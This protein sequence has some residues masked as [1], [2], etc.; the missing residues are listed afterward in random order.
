MPPPVIITINSE[1]LNILIPLVKTPPTEHI[2]DIIETALSGLNHLAHSDSAIKQQIAADP[3]IFISIAKLAVVA[4]NDTNLKLQTLVALGLFANPERLAVR[5]VPNF[6]AMLKESMSPDNTSDVQSQAINTAGVLSFD[7]DNQVAM[8]Q[9]PGFLKILIDQLNNLNTQLEQANPLPLDKIAVIKNF[10][11]IIIA[12][13]IRL[14]SNSQNLAHIKQTENFFQTMVYLWK[15]TSFCTELTQLIEFCSRDAEVKPVLAQI[16]G[17]VAMLFTQIT[18]S[19]DNLVLVAKTLANLATLPRIRQ[20]ISQSTPMLKQL[21]TLLSG[22][23]VSAEIKEQVAIIWANLAAESKTL[24]YVSRHAKLIS[25]LINVLI[26]VLKLVNESE[27]LQCQ[28]AQALAHLSDMAPVM[29][30]IH[31]IQGIYNILIKLLSV[32]NIRASVV[33]ILAKSAENKQNLLKLNSNK[34]ILSA[35][36][37]VLKNDDAVPAKYDAVRTLVKLAAVPMN[38]DAMTDFSAFKSV[39]EENDEATK[40][41]TAFALANFANQHPA[42]QNLIGST[43]GMFDTLLQSLAEETYQDDTIIGIARACTSII[44][45]SDHNKDLFG[46]CPNCFETLLGLLG[47]S[48]HDG[49]KENVLHLL[50]NATSLPENQR[51]LSSVDGSFDTLYCFL[52]ASTSE[53]IRQNV[54]HVL[55]YM[56]YDSTIQTSIKNTPAVFG[57]LQGLMESS[58]DSAETKSNA[59]CI[60]SNLMNSTNRVEIGKIRDI[61]N[62]LFGLLMGETCGKEHALYILAELSSE[63]GNV[64]EIDKLENKSTLFGRLVEFIKIN[65]AKNKSNALRTLANLASTSKNRGEISTVESVWPALSSFIN[66]RL[67]NEN[68]SDHEE[69]ARFLGYL[70]EEIPKRTK[71]GELQSV[72]PYLAR[73]VQQNNPTVQYHALRVLANLVTD[74]PKNQSK[75]VGV[76]GIF[77]LLK[78]RLVANNE[79][80]V[81]S[82]VVRILSNLP[83]IHSECLSIDHVSTIQLVTSLVEAIEKPSSDIKLQTMATRALG[84]LAVFRHRETTIVNS[85]LLRVLSD[86]II[87]VN[88]GSVFEKIATEAMRALAKL[89][90]QHHGNQEHIISI[91]SLS[92]SLINILTNTRRSDITR[93]QAARCLAYITY[94]NNATQNLVIQHHADLF[95]KLVS[96][97]NSSQHSTSLD[98]KAEIAG[99]LASLAVNHSVHQLSIGNIE[100]IFKTLTT[101]LGT[102]SEKA[103]SESAR[104]IA[105]LAILDE[106]K[107]KILTQ[108]STVFSILKALIVI[109]NPEDRLKM[110]T[111]VEAVHALENLAGNHS[112]TQTTIGKID[113]IYEALLNLI[114]LR[115]GDERL[116]FHAVRALTNLSVVEDNQS[117]LRRVSTVFVDLKSALECTQNIGIK[118]EIIG[119]LSLLALKQQ[120]TIGATPG[121]F[122]VFAALLR[123]ENS[124][125]KLK[126][127]T[128]GLVS[129]LAEFRQ[130]VQHIKADDALSTAFRILEQGG[131]EGIQQQLRKLKAKLSKPTHS[132]DE[133]DEGTQFKRQERGVGDR[134]RHRFMADQGSSEQQMPQTQRDLG[135][136]KKSSH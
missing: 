85:N 99:V 41:E 134:H 123:A 132:V 106:N 37:D 28:V 135:D 105:E 6:F 128:L 88:D 111:S 77:N 114:K 80:D 45:N 112:L 127:D 58:Q 108:A 95:T 73:L 33:H 52:T 68:E 71:I 2:I 65:D 26:N 51:R 124:N 29:E 61:F 42:N 115:G 21:E 32:P 130:N 54:S 34:H 49:V 102:E 39:L 1:N 89:A 18:P 47:S 64:T 125:E 60:L 119:L 131:S 90:F 57:F 11:D 55:A 66:C 10:R 59:T 20:S 81:Q 30:E 91:P 22:S 113:K 62:T 69:A 76:S 27:L 97:L 93:V 31:A 19:N 103:K 94:K 79:L 12:T 67:T 110:N 43:L 56:T 9:V 126:V 133:D 86:Q 100:N 98:I 46:S 3:A 92:G 13:L 96:V 15:A 16:E 109:V 5:D 82:E 23:S 75:L 101:L 40:K 70:S 78:Q 87:R 121:I 83:S 129:Q 48:R 8:G 72:F 136:G 63:P 74:H 17:I 38:K 7:N 36:L 4:K 53:Q 122:G 35:L 120:V 50:A 25:V 24:E 104:L 107:N 14:V 44:F 84:N 116:K 117:K 118:I